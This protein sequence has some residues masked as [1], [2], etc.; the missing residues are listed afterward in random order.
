MRP[1]ARRSNSPGWASSRVSIRA[2]WS[3]YPASKTCRL[4]RRVRDEAT[5]GPLAADC[6]R[7]FRRGRCVVFLR[8]PSVHHQIIS[9]LWPRHLRIAAAAERPVLAQLSAA[10]DAI[11]T[12][13][14]DVAELICD[15]TSAAVTLVVTAE[16][17][18]CRSTGILAGDHRPDGPGAALG[19]DQPHR[20]RSNRGR[21]SRHRAGP[22]GRR[23]PRVLAADESD[24]VRVYEVATAPTPARPGRPS[25]QTRCHAR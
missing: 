15:P 14:L 6:A 10:V 7:L 21:G 18:G 4:L 12:D 8:A 16:Q 19:G 11:D 3:G 23:D 24:S 17:S 1:P 2:S 25:A 13:C 5:S 20:T 22:G 9:R